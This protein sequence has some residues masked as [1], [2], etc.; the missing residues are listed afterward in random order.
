MPRSAPAPSAMIMSSP[1]GVA[2]RSTNQRASSAMEQLP[3]N[4]VGGVGRPQMLRRIGAPGPPRLGTPDEIGRRRPL[5]VDQRGAAQQADIGSGKGVGLA[6]RAQR[7]VL[8][9]PF[10]D[11]ADGAQPLHRLLD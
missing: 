6:Q 2:V 10:A 11:A 7:D 4:E 9:R 1:S 3:V 5:A 8:R